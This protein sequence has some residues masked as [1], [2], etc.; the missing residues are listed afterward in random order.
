MI[1]NSGS[2]WGFYL[3]TTVDDGGFHQWW[4]TT[5]IHNT[6][7]F[8]VETFHHPTGTSVRLLL[9]EQAKDILDENSKIY[10]DAD[11]MQDFSLLMADKLTVEQAVSAFEWW[12]K[13]S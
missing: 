1:Q 12:C 7:A 9:E 6:L 8:V 4:M 3:F 11:A 13:N 10:Q 5:T 2:D